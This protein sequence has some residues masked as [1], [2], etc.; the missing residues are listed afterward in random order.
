MLGSVAYDLWG[1]GVYTARAQSHLRQEIARFGFPVRPIPRHADGFLRIPRLALDMAL[2]EG[3]EPE[4][5][6]EG[7]GH[8]P[9][10]PLPGYG[11]NVAIAGHR[12]THLAPFWALNSLLPGDV[13]T[14]ETRAG[15]FV[16]QVRWKRV[17]GPNEWWVTDQTVTPSLT[18][19]TC[20]PRF[21]STGRLVVRAV[22][23]YGRVPGGFL[24]ADDPVQRWPRGGGPA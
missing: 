4:D 24:G 1:T 14:L 3:I 15:Y 2:V 5:L 18:L 22:Q 8:Y 23:T 9:N 13:I 19:T 16:Y 11:G 7:P 20:E 6:A 12:T 21:S 10:T 17:L